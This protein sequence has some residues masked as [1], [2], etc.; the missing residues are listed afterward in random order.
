MCTVG[1][2]YYGSPL[3]TMYLDV[4]VGGGVESVR[5]VRPILEGGETLQVKLLRRA[6][7]PSCRELG[8]ELERLHHVT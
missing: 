6:P 1:P 4:V 3:Y 5:G 7:A 2:I 8:P